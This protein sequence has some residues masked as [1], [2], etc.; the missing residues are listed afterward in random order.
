MQR[1]SQ[2]DTRTEELNIFEMGKLKAVLKT[3]ALIE[4]VLRKMVLELLYFS[5]DGE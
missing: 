1:N 3:S 2:N 4:R 5:H